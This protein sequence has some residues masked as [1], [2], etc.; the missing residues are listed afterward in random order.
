M[1]IVSTFGDFGS[2]IDN[3]PIML[4]FSDYAYYVR[5]IS[6][7]LWVLRFFDDN[8]FV[9]HNFNVWLSENPAVFCFSPIDAIIKHNTGVSK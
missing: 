3:C 9:L 2:V 7:C 4:S 5:N 6:L 1:A 8:C